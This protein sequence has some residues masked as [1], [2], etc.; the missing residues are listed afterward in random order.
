LSNLR[1]TSSISVYLVGVYR[2]PTAGSRSTRTFTL[3][4]PK[5]RC[6]STPLGSST[7]SLLSALPRTCYRKIR[8]RGIARPTVL[9][10]ESSSRNPDGRSQPRVVSTRSA[11][12]DLSTSRVPKLRCHASVPP[13]LHYV[14]G[15]PLC[16]VTFGAS[17]FSEPTTSS[18]W[19]LKSPNVESLMLRIRAT[20]PSRNRRSRSIW[21]IALR[22]FDVHA[23]IA[24]VNPDSPM[25]DS[26][27]SSVRLRLKPPRNSFYNQRCTRVR[28]SPRSVPVADSLPRENPPFITFGLCNLH[29]EYP[30]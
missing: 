10:Q 27:G 6:S 5:R 30:S 18:P 15:V 29:K 12:L 19:Q 9:F 24:L 4:G 20:C 2:A 25:R 28:D 14:S 23:I 22:G 13:G 1:Y 7:H 16:H 26:E 8:P 21:G 17:R 11:S 3:Y